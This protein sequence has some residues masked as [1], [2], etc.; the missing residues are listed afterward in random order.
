MVSSRG[1]K[2]IRK[3]KAELRYFKLRGILLA[4]AEIQNSIYTTQEHSA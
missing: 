4:M 2:C 1:S 3:S